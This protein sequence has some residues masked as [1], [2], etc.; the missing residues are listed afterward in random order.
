KADFT[1]TFRSLTLGEFCGMKL[2]DTEDFSGWRQKWEKRLKKEGK[3]KEE[4]FR[5]MKD[6]NPSIIPRNYLVEE[7]LEAAVKDGDYSKLN[8]LVDTLSDPYGYSKEQE[9]FAK[10]PPEPK[11][12]YRTFCGT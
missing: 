2:F 7:A 10:L 11:T 9:A 1:N 5:L 3:S 6:N 12:P 8:R 4:V